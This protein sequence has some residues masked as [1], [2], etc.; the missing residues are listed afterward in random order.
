MPWNVPTP[1]DIAAKLRAGFDGELDG[2]MARLWPNNV[3][4]SAKVYAGGLSEVYDYQSWIKEQIFVRSCADEVLEDHGGDLELPIRRATAA[5]GQVTATATAAVVIR[6]GT[7]LRRADGAAFVVATDAGIGGAGPLSLNVV[8]V[9]AGAASVTLPGVAL[10]IDGTAALTAVAVGPSGLT[11]GA[12]QESYDDYRARLL[13][14]K[15][16]RPGHARPSDYVIWANEVPGVSRVFVERK[17]Y[18]PGTVR[19]YV[20]FD[21][22]YLNGIPP[23]GEIA[24]VQDHLDI[25]GASG[26]A[27][28]I[29]AAPT[30][31]VIPIEIGSLS[32]NSVTVKNTVLD[33]IT[34][35]FRRRAVVA[36][37]DPGHRAMPFLATAQTFSRSWIG[38]AVANAA[39][40]ARHDLVTPATNVVVTPGS[41]PVPGTPIFS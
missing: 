11:G 9:A 7:I 38:Q 1:D 5:S 32:P 30:A 3:A 33:E 19:V 4:V 8:A 39:G 25:V 20:L 22:I 13:F 28:I 21:G 23:A 24:R 29:V 41:I 40:E 17:P 16:Y 14:F 15:A 2:A 6:A 26:V 36:G 10:A 31:Q 37:I 35:L 27:D 34:E 12:D 18:G